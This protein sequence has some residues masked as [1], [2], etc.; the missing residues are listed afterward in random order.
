MHAA[1]SNSNINAL[2]NKD[3]VAT[4]F[5]RLSPSLETVIGLGYW[6]SR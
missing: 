5:R 4:Q 1:E 2:M 3:P 6:G